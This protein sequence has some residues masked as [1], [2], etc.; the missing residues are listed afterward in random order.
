MK[1]KNLLLSVIFLS[2]IAL[3]FSFKHKNERFVSIEA[4]N[5]S[6]VDS[7]SAEIFP[8]YFENQCYIRGLSDPN[9]EIRIEVFNANG[10]LVKTFVLEDALSQNEIT[11]DLS[12]LTQKVLIV[13][14]YEDQE[15]LNKVRLMKK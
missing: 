7:S 2:V 4:I 12:D 3:S 14:V 5:T 13:R 11:L 8:T 9:K 10:L 15:L 6:F 1:K